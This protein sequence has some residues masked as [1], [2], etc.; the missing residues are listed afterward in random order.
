[1]TCGPCETNDGAAEYEIGA[2]ANGA[3]GAAEY[4]IGAGAGAY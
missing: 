3:N 1:M 2:G 4:E